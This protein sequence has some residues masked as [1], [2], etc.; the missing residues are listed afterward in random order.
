M[1][2]VFSAEEIKMEEM[3]ERLKR[4]EPELEDLIERALREDIGKGDITTHLVVGE[5][6]KARGT[7]LAEE[8]SVLC[9]LYLVRRVF[10]KLDPGAKFHSSLKDGDEVDS[11]KIVAEIEAK[12]GAILTGERLSLNFLQQLS[13]ISTYTR[14]FVK[15]VEGTGVKIAATR[16]TVPGLRGLQK[17][18]VETGGGITH[19]MRLDDGI[20]IK[21]NHLALCGDIAEAVRKAKAGAPKGMK[22][23]VEVESL[24][25]LHRVLDAGA[26]I[27]LLDN[28]NLE[29][30][31]E[32]VRINA[33]RAILE[34]SGGVKLENAR[35]IAQSGVDIISVGAL[36][37]S[38]P[39]V[40]FTMKIKPLNE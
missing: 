35:A 30:L 38:A 10:E 16:K 9:G 11:G 17:Y 31:K 6:G 26:D 12:A 32:A 5:G 21:D 18:A 13:G 22:V 8:K 33:K 24:G 40:H 34:A 1:T 7:I 2:E 15:A 28:M 37:H 27:I 29:K 39:S 20:L 23:E 19:R 3:I 14:R 36:T 25:E 4:F